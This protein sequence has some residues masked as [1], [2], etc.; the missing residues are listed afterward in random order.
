MIL[1]PIALFV[2]NRPRH[3]KLAVEALLRNELAQES[4]LYVYLD[5]PKSTEDKAKGREIIKYVHSLEGFKSVTLIERTRNLGL[6]RSIISGVTELISKYGRII[7]LEDDMVSSPF[8]LRFMNDALEF[9]KDEDKVISIHG[10]TFPFGKFPM[11]TFFI[12]GADCW[13]WATWQR[14]WDLFEADGTKLLNEIVRRK[15]VKAFDR[16]NDS[17][18]MLKDQIA[19]RNDSWAIRWR[20]SAFLQDKL[21]LYSNR[22]LIKNIGHDGSGVHCG[23]TTGFDVELADLPVS[24]R[25]IPIRENKPVLRALEKYF[26]RQNPKPSFMTRVWSK[27][28]RILKGKEFR[29]LYKLPRYQSAKVQLFSKSLELVDPASFLSSYEE[30]FNKEIYRFSTNVQCPYIIDC[31]ANIGLSL[32]YFKRLFPKATIIGF[33]PDPRVFGVLERNIKS[34]QLQDIT[35]FQKAVWTS[36]TKLDFFSEGADAGRIAVSADQ[37]KII[38]IETVR[39]K[40]HLKGNIDFLKVDIEGAETEVLKDCQEELKNVRNIFVE[41]HS[42]VGEEQTLDELLHTLSQ[43]GFKYSIHQQGVFS[44][45]PFVRINT[46][47][48]MDLQLNI[49]AFRK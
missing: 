47:C 29:Q 33:E 49:F 2:Y 26:Q 11:E 9:Y 5:G 40:D 36:E 12:K 39:L 16:Y 31:G 28:K 18:Q 25:A 44:P 8:F 45:N 10:Y 4:D 24:V 41:Y 43:A 35:L 38:T 21:T 46:S 14:G 34:F 3:T 17:V 7:V 1:S 42:F 22:S 15:A 48:A 6:A 37:E 20:A 30:I 19:G 32:I 23:A 13:G 27:G